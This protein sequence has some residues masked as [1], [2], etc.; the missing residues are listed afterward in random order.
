MA[1]LTVQTPR[2]QVS[3]RSERLVVVQPGAEEE[4][5]KSDVPLG[6]LER[7]VFAQG[8][9]V[10]TSALCELL[11][12]RI[13]VV[14][15][16]WNGR[17]LGSFEPPCP[18]RG[19]SRM[20]QYQVASEPAASLVIAVKLVHAKIANGRRLLQRLDANHHRL[21]PGTLEVL[22]RCEREAVRTPDLAALRG[23][24]GG[25]AAAF[26]D[27][28]SRFLPGEFPFVQRS[29]RP[30]RNPVNACLSYLAAVVYGEVL[31]ACVVRGLDPALGCLHQ[32]DDG[33]WSL[34]LDLMEPF[35]PALIEALTLRLFSHRILQSADFEGRDGGV[36]LNLAGRR[37]LM[38]HY[39]QRVQREFLSEHVGCRTTLRQQLEQAA[40]GFKLALTGSGSYAPFRL[41]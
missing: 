27:G 34:P 38:Q 1:V 31:S 11:A 3:L 40:L 16:G 28:W 35:R 20:L 6:D 10:S 2:T 19:A 29:T 18:P 5:A 4:G 7:A 14:F 39:E 41:N 23:F 8:V 37:K 25:A 26:F 32:S 22:E 12:R 17:F 9:Q 15:L 36:W 13:P 30:P 24:E 33:R 21:E